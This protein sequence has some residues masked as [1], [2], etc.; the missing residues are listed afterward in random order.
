MD[1]SSLETLAQTPEVVAMLRR[2]PM[3][4]LLKASKYLFGH[5]KLGVKIKFGLIR[6][7]AAESL[8]QSWA[9]HFG[10]D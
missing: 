7:V 1:A 5:G 6:K 3:K 2:L 10:R 9:K 8:S 4:T